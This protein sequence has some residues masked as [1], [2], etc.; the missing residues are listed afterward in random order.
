[1]RIQP[2][3]ISLGKTLADSNNTIF[4]INK[5]DKCDYFCILRFLKMKNILFLMGVYPGIG[6]V[7]IVSTV[8]ANAFIEK[9]HEVTLCSFESKDDAVL[10]RLSPKAQL[11]KLEYPVS[12]S[13]NCR[14]LHD[15]II[16]H[17]VEVIIDQWAMPYYVA[18]LCRQATKRTSCKLIVVHHNL[19]NTNNHIKELEGKIAEGGFQLLNKM[20]LAAVRLASRLSLRYTYG[21]CDR[22]VVL[23][24]R[25][26]GMTSQFIWK[27]HCSKLV[28]I[29][30]PITI[31][32]EYSELGIK[33]NVVLYVGRIEYKQKRND[34]LV[35]V[36][37]EMGEIRKGWKL[38]IVGD[39]PDRHNLQK[40]IEQRNLSDSVEIVGFQSPVDYYKRAK[41]LL[42]TSDYE[43]FGLVIVEAMKFGAVPIVYG[44]YE[45]V[46]DIVDS[47]KHG[48]ITP[49]PFSAQETADVL[50]RLMSDDALRSQMSRRAVERSK[51]FNLDS[52]VRR[53]EDLVSC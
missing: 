27:N 15:Y 39:G 7:E 35:D 25:F 4:R 42:L 18:R 2:I 43:G 9:G 16:S 38:V 14:I 41:F 46:Y 24:S 8:L 20:K 47:G 53:W 12:S 45:A 34:R 10:C 26:F 28:S 36:W 48:F 5:I 21:K 33:E 40:L 3:F 31:D 6:G 19:P 51:D 23:S 13:S 22:F 17:N 32:G 37:N 1:M 29:P 49:M 52:V 30:N 11:L 50:S 44:S